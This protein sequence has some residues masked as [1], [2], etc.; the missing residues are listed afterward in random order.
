MNIYLCS[1]CVFNCPSK[2]RTK[3]ECKLHMTEEQL[4]GKKNG[5]LQADRLPVVSIFDRPKKRNKR[6]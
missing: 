4:H 3:L 2:Y 5:S 1:N 6:R